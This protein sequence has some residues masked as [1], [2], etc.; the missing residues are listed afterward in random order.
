MNLVFDKV[1]IVKTSLVEFC[2]CM[3]RSE[4]NEL[5]LQYAVIAIHNALQ[6]TMTLT[7]GNPEIANTWKKPH[8]KK[9]AEEE[10]PKQLATQGLYQPDKFPQLDF[11]MELYDKYFSS[12]PNVINRDYINDL[13][14]HR[15]NFIDFNTDI[16]SLE[17]QYIIT[18]CSEG[19]KAII[20]I[21]KK[22][23]EIFGS[24]QKSI[25]DLLIKAQGYLN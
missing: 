7:L 9:W 20:Y 16:L 11:F 14:N 24:A 12:N 21:L 4:S 15:N 5:L 13:N 18:S 22:E 23:N 19:V 1:N 10:L 8:A 17:K 25:E 2:S 6:G 3:E